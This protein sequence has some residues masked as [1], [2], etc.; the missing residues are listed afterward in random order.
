MEKIILLGEV[1][2]VT[3]REDKSSDYR[4]L[5]D[6]AAKRAALQ[7]VGQLPER[8]ADALL[9]LKYAEVLVRG[10]LAADPTAVLKL[11]STDR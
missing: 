6:S 3:K 2:T 8:Q 5:D 7:I 4:E 11:V 9:V 10:F 1:R